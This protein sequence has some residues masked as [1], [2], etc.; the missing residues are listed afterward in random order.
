MFDSIF[1][2][3]FAENF[4]ELIITLFAVLMAL[5]LHEFAHGY[6][7]Y[8]LGDNTA[9]YM[10]RLSLNPIHHLDPL[11]TLCMVLFHF[12]WARPVPINPANFN[13]PKRDFAITASMG[14][15]TNTVLG[16]ISAFF[17]LLFVKL[18]LEVGYFSDIPM[19]YNL[20]YY[21]A[22]FF[23][24][25]FSVNIGLGLFNL[26]PIPPFDGSRLLNA[27]LPDRIYFKIMKYER[28]IYLG[29]VAWLLLGPYVYRMLMSFAFIATNPVL[30]NLFRIFSLSGL[31]SDASGFICNAILAF[32]KLI[33]I[34]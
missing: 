31:I 9:K 26:I 2:G 12:G 7:A 11:G 32:W 1:T 23:G 34:F 33:P 13:K 18:F 6:T 19:I 16:F 30:A 28:Q 21:L 24:I 29:I 4:S 17:Y 25:F 22:R 14:P 10:G 8:K 15:L 20:T 27:L 3:S 5:T